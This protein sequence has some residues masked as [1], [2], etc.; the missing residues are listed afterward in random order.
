MP[1]QLTQHEIRQRA[2]Q[3]L[4]SYDVQKEMSENVLQAFQKQTENVKAI[5]M[6]P[7]PRFEIRFEDE[8]IVIRDFPKRL[9]A[10][11]NALVEI[12][13]ILGI[14]LEQSALSKALIFARDFGGF[15]K[16]ATNEE[17]TTIFKTIFSN[18]NLVKF[19]SLEL[20]EGSV[21]K[22]FLEFVNQTRTANPE[23]ALEVFNQIFIKIHENI[24]E[25]Y[26]SDLFVPLTLSVELDRELANAEQNLTEKKAN[27]LLQTKNFVLN[28]DNESEEIPTAPKYFKQLVDGVIENQRILEATIGQHLAQNWSFA[29]LTT[30]ERAILS[31]GAYE[32]IF[33]EVPDVVA[34]DEAIELSKD[35]SD[36]KS[37]KFINGVL[38]N[39]IKAV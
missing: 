11:L 32:I 13:E 21:T 35:F 36:E 26:T 20:E 24:R 33:T 37:S 27:L 10:A 4:F 9:S 14:S 12:Y 30:V 38:T 15:T 1:K 7:Y 2:V 22:K 3:T 31:I 23:Q 18:L 28:Y 17:A 6:K 19:L 29:R 39:L 16:K 5:L 25:K 8:R 34:I